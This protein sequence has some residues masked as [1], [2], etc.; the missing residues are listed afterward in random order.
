MRRPSTITVQRRRH[1]IPAPTIPRSSLRLDFRHATTCSPGYLI[2]MFVKEALPGDTF[3]LT[4][5]I[6]ARFATLA[7]PIISNVWCDWHAFFVPNRLVWDDWQKF[8]GEREDPTD[9]IDNYLIPTA[10]TVTGVLEESLYDYMGIPPGIA[11]LTWN[12]LPVRGYS[13]IW[14]EWFR[15]Q[16]LQDSLPVDK[17]AGPDSEDDYALVKRCKPQDYFT[18]ARPWPQRGDS[19]SLP[20]GTDAPIT[21]IGKINQVFNQTSVSAYETDGSG[22][23]TYATAST[24]DGATND[25]YY[26]EQDPDNTGYPNIRADLTNATAATVNQLRYALALQLMLEREA[27]GGSRYAEILRS[28]FGVTPED[29]RLQ[30]P[31]L[32]ATGSFPINTI[33]VPSNAHYATAARVGDLGA[34]GIGFGQPGR[35]V[36]SFTEHGWV[37]GLVSIRCQLDYQQGLA[38]QWSR[39]TRYDHYW[40]PFAQLGE[41]EVLSKELYADG[42]SNDD[43]VW[44]YQERW[45]EYRTA[46]NMLTGQFRSSAA[47]P[48]DAWHLAQEF[49]SRPTLNSTFIQD[50]PPVD[51]VVALTAQC[52]F[53]VDCFFQWI[54]TR[55]MPT[56]SIPGLLPRL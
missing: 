17:D 26:V 9:T 34:Y 6:M 12:Q 45:A 32:L 18:S 5:N 43:D 24:V 37:I 15:D 1:D 19:V 40:P 52:E 56:Y 22:T 3:N 31:E 53:F 8:C 23:E 35:F 14:N 36:R 54:A 39:S 41:Q 29:A 28:M 50:T 38:R 2:P 49:G 21:G 16:G 46:H 48:L 11:G 20:L 47:A 42:T 25:G 10:T 4:P 55:P 7:N 27:R 51:R 44:G 30:R 13:L 33:T